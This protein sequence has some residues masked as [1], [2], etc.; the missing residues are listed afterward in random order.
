MHLRDYQELALQKLRDSMRTGNKKL[1]LVAPT[2]SGKTVIAGAMIKA[3]VDKSNN[4]LFVA[5]RRELIDQCSDKLR[6]FDVNHGVIMAGRS[7]NIGARTQVASIQTFTIRKENKFFNKPNADVIIL[8]EAHRSV[9]KSF[10]DLIEEYPEA[11]VIGLTATPV[12]ND[13]KGLGGIYDDL[14]E[15]GSIR[16]LTEEG[17][18]V[19]NRVV[20]PTMPDL[21]GLKIMAGDYEK[22]GLNKRMNTPKLVGD[23]VTHWLRH[24]EGRPTVVFATSIA[25]SKYISKIFND[26]GIPAGHVDGDMDELEREQVL[27][28]LHHG[29]IKVLSNCQVLTEGWDEPKVSCVVLARPTKSYGMY[30][31]MV[32]RSLR[33]FENKKDT[34]IIDHAG[35]VYEHGFPED[36]PDWE[37]TADK[38]TRQQKKERKEI[39]KQPFTCTKCNA[40]YHPTRI[41]RTCPVCGHA[42]TEAD[43]KVLIK[44]GR[45]VELPKADI[46]AQDKQEFYAQLLFHSKQKGYKE[47]WA[48][49]TFKEKFGHFPHSK[50]VMPKPVGDEVKGYLRHL[51]I[52]KAKSNGGAYV[53]GR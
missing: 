33:P 34:L 8:D 44:Q 7:A 20:A 45:L 22:R 42:P 1:L 29:K 16:K 36:V 49:W 5:H 39:D 15:C 32:G 47:G 18:L 24:A 19:P 38:I 25:H 9:S 3:A 6:Q 13:G 27:H 26:N 43:K 21:D 28:D 40:V 17:Y 48:S 4:C 23:L 50:R 53:R 46:N 51:Q 11:Y 37:L 41:L 14:I 31:Q 2:G 52:K 35:C 10:K 12:R 30:L